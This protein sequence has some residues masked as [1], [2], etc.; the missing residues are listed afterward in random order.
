[1]EWINFLVGNTFISV[2]DFNVRQKMGIPMGTNAAPQIADLYLLA[3][4]IRFMKE[5][6]RGRFS[7]C[8][9]LRYV[10]RYLDDITI[11]N[12]KGC[13]SKEIG[14]IYDNCLDL[15]K[16]NSSPLEAEVLDISVR[17]SD[18]SAITTVF[19]KRKSFNFRVNQLPAADSNIAIATMYSVFYSQLIRIARI[20]SHQE[21][22]IYSCQ[23]LVQLLSSKGYSRRKMK[24]KFLQFFRKKDSLVAK[25]GTL[26]PETLWIT[27]SKRNTLDQ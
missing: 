13:F 23:E 22:F 17:I 15:S 25:Y 10:Y 2:G 7:I 6:I 24:D 14:S 16:V 27:V 12:D 5:N 11:I 18:G 26:S 9:N 21:G 20:C 1:M 19:D 8:F 3:Q 4:E